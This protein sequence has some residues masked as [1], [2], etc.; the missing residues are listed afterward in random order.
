MAKTNIQKQ[1]SYVTNY[2]SHSIYVLMMQTPPPKFYN[3][4]L[5]K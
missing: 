4:S 2:I 3:Q 1:T 5:L